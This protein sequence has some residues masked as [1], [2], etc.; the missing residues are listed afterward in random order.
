MCT[1]QCSRLK[2]LKQLNK[3]YIIGDVKNTWKLC[4]VILTVFVVMGAGFADGRL[5]K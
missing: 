4:L 2:F 1:C 3:I 5:L